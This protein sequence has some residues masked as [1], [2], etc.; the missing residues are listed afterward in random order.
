[1]L[2]TSWTSCAASTAWAPRRTSAKCGSPKNRS[3]G[4]ATTNAIESLR[5]VISERAARLVT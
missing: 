1:M 3:S 2:K 5:R 4:S